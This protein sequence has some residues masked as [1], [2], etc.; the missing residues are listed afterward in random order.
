MAGIPCRITARQTRDHLGRRPL[1]GDIFID[2]LSKCAHYELRESIWDVKIR[3]LRNVE[4]VTL[5]DSAKF[6]LIA[7]FLQW[8][9]H[10]TLSTQVRAGH[11]MNVRLI[12][13]DSVEYRSRGYQIFK[14]ILTK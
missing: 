6:G 7:F 4:L 2:D 9:E 12:R 11:W 13:I 8:S 1:A 10:Y 5:L 14:K 3:R